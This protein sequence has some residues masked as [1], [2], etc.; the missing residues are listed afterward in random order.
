MARSGVKWPSKPPS[1]ST[2]R[3]ATPGSSPGT[4]LP[5]A[6]RLSMTMSHR[7]AQ[8]WPALALEAKKYPNPRWKHPVHAPPE[9]IWRCFH[10]SIVSNGHMI[11]HHGCTCK[12]IDRSAPHYYLYHR[13]TRNTR[14][15][16]WGMSRVRSEFKNRTEQTTTAVAL[17]PVS[18]L[19]VNRTRRH[20]SPEASPMPFGVE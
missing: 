8:R 4:F 19:N 2:R 10:A 15:L 13:V 9:R 16:L 14:P 17:F 5:A 12:C 20:T 6:R 7:T 3:P 11:G 18:Q 1:G